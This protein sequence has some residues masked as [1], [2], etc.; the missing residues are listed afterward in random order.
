MWHFTRDGWTLVSKVVTINISPQHPS[1]RILRTAW[2]HSE[3][4]VLGSYQNTALSPSSPAQILYR[5]RWSFTDWSLS[6]L[7]HS[8]SL[9]FKSLVFIT[10]RSRHIFGTDDNV[11]H[12]VQLMVGA[13]STTTK[14]FVVARGILA[15]PIN[16]TNSTDDVYHSTQLMR[17]AKTT[18]CLT[19]IVKR[20]TLH[21]PTGLTSLADNV[22]HVCLFMSRTVKCLRFSNVIIRRNFDAVIGSTNF[23]LNIDHIGK[24]VNGAI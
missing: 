24:L 4:T 21:A 7:K 2:L 11:H 13:K 15:A 9:C 5:R 6:L 19:F 18:S 14:P 22:E 16:L 20:W 8:L 10:G 1:K 17:C 12:I 23:V 3:K